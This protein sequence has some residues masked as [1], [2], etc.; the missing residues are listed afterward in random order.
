MHFHWWEGWPIS[1]LVQEV[2][3][4]ENAQDSL[5]FSFNGKLPSMGATKLQPISSKAPLP[6]PTRFVQSFRDRA[7]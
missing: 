3:L 5:C 6:C 4:M 7:F 2:S 1:S